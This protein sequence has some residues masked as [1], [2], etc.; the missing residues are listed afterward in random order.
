MQVAPGTAAKPTQRSNLAAAHLA[1]KARTQR[2]SPEVQPVVDCGTV[3]WNLQIRLTVAY[4]ASDHVGT[5]PGLGE[6][7]LQSARKCAARNLD[8]AVLDS[9][10]ELQNH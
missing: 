4:A 3:D 8:E 10:A 6:R 7:R 5:V 9:L 1:K 2:V